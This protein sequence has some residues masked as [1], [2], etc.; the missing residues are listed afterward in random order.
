MELRLISYPD[1][2][3]NEAKLINELFALGL[4]HFHLRKPDW[5]EEKVTKLLKQIDSRFHSRIVIHDRFSLAAKFDLG[6][7]HFTYR[8]H[9][10]MAEWLPF[11]ISKSTSCHT[12]DELVNLPVGI[13]F[14]FLSPIFSSVSKPGY[15]ADF[16]LDMLQNFLSKFNRCKVVALGGICHSNIE[17]CRQLGFDEV[18]ALGTIWNPTLTTMQIIA[19]FLKLKEA[20]LPSALS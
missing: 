10:K 6:G 2:F 20:C 3:A 1:S 11:Q 18:A 9:E 7:I 8:T 12:T 13:D 17:T 5:N 4:M 16:D 15:S 19:Q 14:A